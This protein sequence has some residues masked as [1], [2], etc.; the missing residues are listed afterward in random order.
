[1]IY[2]SIGLPCRFA[3]W[4]DHV[5]ARLIEHSLG[6][7]ETFHVHTLDE[8][9]LAAI[10]ANSPYVLVTSRNPVGRLQA[11]IAGGGGRVL[12][13]LDEPRR[14][15]EDLVL[16][17]G[18]DLLEA[19]RLASA[20]CA[21][22]VGGAAVPNALVLRPSD[23]ADD[24]RAMAARIAGH[25]GFEVGEDDLGV[26]IG[27]LAA[28]GISPHRDRADGWWDQLSDPERAIVQ[29]ALDYYRQRFSGGPTEPIAWERELFFIN[30]ETSPDA[31][32]AATRAVDITGR[33]R[34]L[35]YGP[36]ISL[37]P[38]AW[39]ATVALGFSSEAAAI[40]YQAEI[41]AGTQL[42][43]VR[44]TPANDPFVE[45]H[46]DFSIDD[47]ISEPLQ[48]RIWSERAAFE[49]RVALGHVTITPQGLIRSDTL[50]YFT[51]ALNE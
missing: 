28:A 46:L 47:S 30:E 48:I 7:L 44:V 13:S 15:L 40:T 50:E 25:F 29:G 4:C 22:M 16:A 20:S 18:T 5:M 33:A 42:T 45:L 11:A 8:F 27:D 23:E 35:I 49:G 24:P 37:P 31:H 32:A 38:G 19:T 39:S 10:R 9:A 17:Q 3:E 12:V 1:M 36:F 41:W 21:S 43:S 14:A 6:P 51:T 2:F 26:I 34:C